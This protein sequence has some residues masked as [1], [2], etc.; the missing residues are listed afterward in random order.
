L[1]ESIHTVKE[2]SEVLVVARKE[3]GIEVYADKTQYMVISRNQNA[4]HSKNVESRTFEGVEEFK[5]F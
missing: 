1:G 5:Y 4:S 2:N 3:T